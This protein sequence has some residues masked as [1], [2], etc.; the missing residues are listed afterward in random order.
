MAI[1]KSNKHKLSLEHDKPNE[2][3]GCTLVTLYALMKLLTLDSQISNHF[4]RLLLS[5][6]LKV[7]L[8]LNKWARELEWRRWGCIYRPKP[9]IQP[10]PPT[11]AVSGAPDALA[12]QRRMRLA[13]RLANTNSVKHPACAGRAR[14]SVR[15]SIL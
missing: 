9:K 15:R 8:Q 7:F 11:S 13:V 14:L 10:L 6:A 2:K 3:G 12:P 5:L 4:N 1:T